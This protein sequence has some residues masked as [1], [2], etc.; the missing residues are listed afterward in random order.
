MN[1]QISFAQ[2]L[3]EGNHT[4]DESVD[5]NHKEDQQHQK[6]QQEQQQLQQEQQ[7]I[8]NNTEHNNTENHSVRKHSNKNGGE[9]STLD[10]SGQDEKMENGT[11]ELNEESKHI[12]EINCSSNT[13]NKSIYEVTN[14]EKNEDEPIPLS[15]EIQIY[16]PENLR[17]SPVTRRYININE[18]IE[19]N[20]KD[21]LAHIRLLELERELRGEI[22]NNSKKIKEIEEQIKRKN[23]PERNKNSEATKVKNV[24]STKEIK[25]KSIPVTQKK[26]E[27]PKTM[28]YMIGDSHL[29]YIQNIM[30]KNENFVQNYSVQVHMKPG[31]GIE[32][33]CKLVPK[34]MEKSSILVVCA[35][36]NDLYRTEFSTFQREI[37]KLAK[38]Q[39]RIIVLTVPPQHCIYTNSDIIKLNTRIKYLCKKYPNIEL[40]KTHAFIKIQHLARDG[41]H[42]SRRAKTWLATKII[43]V[44]N[45]E[46]EEEEKGMW[47]NG[48]FFRQHSES[49]NKNANGHVGIWQNGKSQSQ[50]SPPFLPPP[51]DKIL[52]TALVGGGGGGGGGGCGGGGG[53]V[54]IIG[55]VDVVISF[56]VRVVFGGK[57][58][59]A[60]ERNWWTGIHS[61]VGN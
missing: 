54:L 53:D 5:K 10:K 12:Q 11:I 48:K 39:N 41:V 32:E 55:I 40:L 37:A 22:S 58:G 28:C 52:A 49:D 57:F 19:N 33:I 30:E 18:A 60:I 47:I 46:E 14:N 44:I 29:R 8:R 17:I 56:V 50:G 24:D 35:G 51:P 38:M 13:G 34:E 31:Q 9:D 3:E 6:Q 15:P 61:N 45:N 7:Q 16:R 43:D 1:Y 20:D 59:A 21:T 2:E 27:K 23:G 36:T 42:L 4:L 26:K 25:S